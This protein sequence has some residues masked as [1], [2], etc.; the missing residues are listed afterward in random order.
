M[1][2]RPIQE[3]EKAS[4]SP[5][6]SVSPMNVGEVELLAE[7]AGRL[8]VRLVGQGA[9]TGRGADDARQ[10]SILVHFDLMGG[11][12]FP[13]S[14]E[15][16]VEAEPG[17]LLL[18]LDNNLHVRG[19]SLTVYPTSAPRSTAGGWLAQDGLGVG[20]FE[21]GWLSENVLSADV[22]LPEAGRRRVR[23]EDLR[24]FMRAEEGAGLVVGAKLQTRRAEADVPFA[25]LFGAP[26]DLA[27]AVIN[28]T[29]AGV[30]LWHLAFVNPGMSLARGF[31]ENYLLFGAYPGERAADAEQGLWSALG[32][33]GGSMLPA[34][35]A[36]R[37]WGERFFPVA[38]S[39]PTPIPE[40]MLVPL[41][42]FAGVLGSM[43]DRPEKN[44]VQG[45]VA[46]S[47]EVLLLSFDAREEFW[48]R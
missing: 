36:H 45:T 14:E 35:H 19:Q 39:H 31:G 44:A 11:M 9:G 43:R 47:R 48:V 29:D 6:A 24:S 8:P 33:R 15:L 4:E 1:K 16:W 28:I 42:E 3:G 5:L 40:R 2:R 18:E 26:Q 7:V 32:T 27:S 34:A 46:R 12:R 23:G 17:A 41:A 13:E 37:V 10:G 21:Y 38:P 20:S 25:A 22:V 30:P